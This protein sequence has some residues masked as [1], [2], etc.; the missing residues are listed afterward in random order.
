MAARPSLEEL[1]RGVAP[2]K[3]DQLCRDD[4]LSEIALSLTDWQSMAPFLGLTEGEEREIE[5][6]SRPAKRRKVAMLRRWKEKYGKKATYR[7]LA[8]VFW[9]LERIDLVEEL[10]EILSECSHSDND[11]SSGG[12]LTS[13]TDYLRGLYQTQLP[14]FLTLQWPPP[15]TRRVFNLAMI[16]GHN[17]RYGPVDEDMVRLMLQGRVKDVLYQKK[18]VK[19]EDI[20][21]M[22]KAKRKVILIEGAPGSGKSTLAWYICQQW[23]SGRLFQDFRTV[24]FV[25]L[26]DP[27]IQ[28]ARSVEDIFPAESRSQ[29]VRVVAELQACRGRDILWV[30]DGWDELPSCLRTNSVFQELIASPQ[31]QNLHFSTV[32][33]T[34]RPIASGDLHRIIT[35]RVEI[36]GFTPTEVKGYF[37]EVVGGNS[38]TVQK[39]QDQ[40]RERPVIEASCYLPLNAAIVTH[41][42][43]AQ[44]HSLPT[45]LHGVFT[46]LVLCCLIR[47]ATK[48]GK[49]F[50]DISS[51][52]NIPPC[53]QTPLDNICALAYHGVMENKVTFSTRELD[54]LR[55]S[56]ELATLGL[57]QGVESLASFKKSISFNFLHLSVQ[58]LLAS[59]YISKLPQ[60]EQVKVFKTLFGQP[61]FAAVFRFYAAFTRLETEGIRE[62]IS[63]IAKKKEN[64]QLLYL[65]NGLY[66][67]QDLSLCQFVGSQLGGELSLVATT[68]SPVDCL[69]VGYFISCICLTT[70]GEFKVN[71]D[72]CSL[73]D[74]RVS[75]L[76]Q[77]LSKCCSSSGTHKTTAT[78][79]GVP[80]CVDL[81]LSTNSI[82]GNG[83]RC[84]AELISHSTVISG[85]HLYDNNIQEGEDG[86]YHLSQALRTNTSLVE[87]DLG[88]CG[89]A[90]EGVEVLS[91][92]LSGN[93]HLKTFVI[94]GNKFGDRGLASLCNNLK[95]ACHLK[96]LSIED[97]GITE[98]GVKVL[99][100]TLLAPVNGSLEEL[101]VGRNAISDAGTAS[102]VK[103]LE[104]NNTLKS[105]GVA[106]CGITEKGAECLAA[107]LRSNKCL[108]SLDLCDNHIADAGIVAITKSLEQSSSFKS[109]NVSGCGITEKGAECLAV[110]LRSNKCLKSLDLHDNHIADAGIV[111]IAKSLEQSYSFKSL[112]VSGCG[113]TE[114]GAE[115]LADCLM[116][117]QSL[118]FLNL[119][120]NQ[121]S[122]TGVALIAN[123]LPHNLTLKKLRLTKCGLTDQCMGPLARALEVNTPLETL[124]L[125]SNQFT[126][127]G[128]VALGESLKKNRGLQTLELNYLK[129]VTGEGLRQFVLSLQENYCLTK[130]D[131][132][133]TGGGSEVVQ[134]EAEVVN[135]RRRQRG[136]TELTVTD[137]V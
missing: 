21:Q 22:D 89:I 109:L 77:E 83:T 38:Q 47:H 42:F 58:E 135:Q 75:L 16:Q 116:V 125:N 33:I 4:H 24:V 94:S 34:S 110:C 101:E 86:L 124:N 63:S 115:S 90:A 18:P 19:L 54:S 64:P 106:N 25:Q 13:Y 136:I 17:I 79:D 3:L 137:D 23:Q 78:D 26:R 52:D 80:G 36:L 134:D 129:K 105:L 87:L 46:S 117:N 113:I 126:D 93:K 69:S 130:L 39:L 68:L 51:L 128:L 122:D 20:F 92:A 43:L 32:V 44:N 74:Y 66:E 112:N 53:Y 120:R 10:C 48:E 50:G 73:D 107:C 5:E 1:L 118:E 96:T 62:I 97:C 103:A 28:S 35:S 37:T 85:V 100:D 55:L 98:K 30:M 49:E 102:I 8:K 119:F 56:G 114:K 11:A 57:I 72:G 132:G 91:H 133:L 111:A 95:A 123:A 67:A 31:V 7:K 82:H 9:K 104:Q 76:V 121:I 59:F 45:T 108:K 61:R 70:S 127:T 71:L 41:L 15:P 40:L 60:S 84:I 2:E 88:K 99:A 12:T 29:A 65:L 27:A 131:V 14:S 81:D 6:D